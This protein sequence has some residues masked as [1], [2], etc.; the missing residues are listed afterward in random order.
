VIMRAPA[1]ITGTMTVPWMPWPG[2]LDSAHAL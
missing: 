2:N 1:E